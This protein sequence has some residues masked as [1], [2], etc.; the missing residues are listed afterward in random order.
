M[1]TSGS[2]Q[3][4]VTVTS[5]TQTDTRTRR[6]SGGNPLTRY[7]PEAVGEHER[8]TIEYATMLIQL[9][10]DIAKQKKSD[11]VQA[12][13]VGLA[14]EA[15]GKTKA[16]TALRRLAELGTLVAGAGLGF[17]GNVVIADDFTAGN[18]LMFMI[19]IAIGMGL[20]TYTLGRD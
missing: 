2:I 1:S 18:T 10:R 11:D 6:N 3:P 13:H 14:A 19:P 8:T 17:L 20:W 12:Y 16:S 15:L 7:S 5:Q 4:S 9:S